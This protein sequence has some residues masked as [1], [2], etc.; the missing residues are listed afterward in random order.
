MNMELTKTN[1]WYWRNEE[2][3]LKE[4]Y[5]LSSIERKEYQN[6]LLNLK[7]TQRST[8]DSIILALSKVKEKDLNFFEL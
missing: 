5:K 1:Q 6:F 3:S 8:V 7:D 4:Y 2:L